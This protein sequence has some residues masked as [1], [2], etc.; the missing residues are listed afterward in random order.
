[1]DSIKYLLSVGSLCAQISPA[2]NAL[3]VF[4]QKRQGAF[5]HFLFLFSFGD[6]MQRQ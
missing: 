1:M 3:N 2:I 4:S 5:F 6:D